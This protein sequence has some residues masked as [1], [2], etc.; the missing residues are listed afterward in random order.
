MTALLRYAHQTFVLPNDETALSYRSLILAILAR[1]RTEWIPITGV[2]DG[3]SVAVDILISPGVDVV[4]QTDDDEGVE[5]A[6]KALHTEYFPQKTT[7]SQQ[8]ATEPV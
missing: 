2:D 7:T 6:L 4:I 8:T 5:G 1:G 3:K